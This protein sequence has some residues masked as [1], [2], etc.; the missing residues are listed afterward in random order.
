MN[1]ERSGNKRGREKKLNK[2]DR[3]AEARGR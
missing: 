1:D 2:Q 3:E